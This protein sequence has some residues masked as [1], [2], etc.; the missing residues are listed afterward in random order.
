MIATWGE[1]Q[2]LPREMIRALGDSGNTP[3]GAFDGDEMIGYVL[4][5]SGVDP[6]EGCTPTPTCWPR[7]PIAATGGWATP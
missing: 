3:W 5:W 2:L 1:H 4:G 6:E 7:C